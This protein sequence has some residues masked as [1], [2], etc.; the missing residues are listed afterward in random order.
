[1]SLGNEV[2]GLLLRAAA[3]RDILHIVGDLEIVAH[4]VKYL[5]KES[6]R[7]I[8]RESHS[9]NLKALHLPL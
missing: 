6:I 4:S 8:Q 3:G 2:Q 5:V 7:H 9:T 1:M